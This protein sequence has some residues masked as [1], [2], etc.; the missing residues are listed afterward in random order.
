MWYIK[1]INISLL[2]Q[3]QNKYI[4][5]TKVTG[6]GILDLKEIRREKGLTGEKIDAQSGISQQHY[7]LIERGERRPSVE[8]AKRIA[9]V[10]GFEWTR[11]YEDGAEEE[12]GGKDGERTGVS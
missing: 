1:S 8:V 12:G 4:S 2:F 9:A 11:F 6:G 10:L 3:Q 7:S 5:V